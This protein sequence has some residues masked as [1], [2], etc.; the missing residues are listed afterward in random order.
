MKD[1]KRYSEAFKLKVM[2]E[3]RDGKWKT[4]ADAAQA[5]GVSAQ[6]VRYW[7]KRLGFEHL[8]GRTIYV[9]TRTELDE[10]KRL[11]AEVRMLKQQLADEVLD[12]K[13][14]EVTLR[15]ACR[16]LGTTPDELKKERRGIMHLTASETKRSVHAIC[17]R[18]DV[19]RAAFYKAAKARPRK[20][21]NEELILALVRQEREVNPCAGTKKVLAAI[22]PELQKAGFDIG[23]NRLGALLK[24]E[25]L[26]VERRKVFHCRTTKQDPS[27][28]PSP[29]LVKDMAIDRPD[30]ALCSDITYIYTE[31]GF[32]YLS[33]VM[34]M[35]AKD[36]VGWALSDTLE[37]EA[38][39][40]KALKMAAKTVGPGKDVVAHS[41]RGC[42]YGSH[43]Y[44]GLL[45]DLGWRSSMT[46]ELHC[47]ENG[48]AER[49]NG[50]LKGEY[51]LDRHFKT[52]AEARKAVEE[53]IWIYNHRRLHEKL[54]YK[55]PAAFRAEWRK[56]A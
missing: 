52:K 51:F 56:V 43:V 15:I 36:I 40:L 49:L 12:H 9:K 47:Y 25:G 46:E 32:L 18:F 31:E 16:N 26:L 48:M 28:V 17:R 50:I 5:C 42:Q 35:F 54:N 55:T 4:V 37:T 21:V 1:K 44:R 27:L 41:D 34:D 19:S 24:R 2:E 53:A 6:G 45:D 38:G 10:I 14:D 20:E 7:M 33:L 29:N 39:P 3:L 11:K 13:I 22:R 8:N 23:R 30:Q